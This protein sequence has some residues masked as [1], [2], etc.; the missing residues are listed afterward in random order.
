MSPSL[1]ITTLFAYERTLPPGTTPRRAC[2][3]RWAKGAGSVDTLALETVGK[4]GGGLGPDLLERYARVQLLQHQRLAGHDLEHAQ[5]GDDHVDH[6]PPG[7][8]QRAF[9]E[10]LRRAVLRRVLH[11]H[12]HPLHARAEA[13]RAA[14]PLHH[15][16]RHDPVGEVA[17]P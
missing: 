8:R 1:T 9:L 7:N 5:V 13:H 6:A 17:V 16:P 10:D 11:Q 15:L 4:L 3:S 14:A 12:H 2:S